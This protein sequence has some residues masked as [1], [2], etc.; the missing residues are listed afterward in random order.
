MKTAVDSSNPPLGY[1][2]LVAENHALASRLTVEAI[3]FRIIS[4]AWLAS[5]LLVPGIVLLMAISIAVVS[6]FTALLW[7]LIV[8]VTARA[9]ARL[10]RALIHFSLA[11]DAGDLEKVYVEWQ[12]S[13]L[14]DSRLRA[15]VSF[16]PFLWFVITTGILI[17]RSF[18]RL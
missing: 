2:L 16:E 3:V 7:K 17:L 13:N 15:L 1:D 9:H 11:D 14:L 5:A 12:H 8:V 6:L 4:F 10:E 18:V